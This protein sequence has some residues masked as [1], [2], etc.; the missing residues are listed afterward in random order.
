MPIKG[1]I[2]KPDITINKADTFTVKFSRFR[3]ILIIDTYVASMVISRHYFWVY[4]YYY[5]YCY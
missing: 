1:N 5:Y 2:I 3:K 4:Y